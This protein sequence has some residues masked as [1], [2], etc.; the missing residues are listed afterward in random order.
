LGLTGNRTTLGARVLKILRTA[1]RTVTPA[2]VIA[3]VAVTTVA[4]PRPAAA[5][6]PAEP[7]SPTGA[8]APAFTRPVAYLRDGNIYV[9]AGATERRLT[10]GGGHARPR[11]SPD[12]RRLAFLRAG[13][14]WVM[15]ADGSGARRLD[16]RPAA[17]PAWSPDGRWIAFSSAGCT[18]VPAIYRISATQPAAAEALFPAACRDEPAPRPPAVAPAPTGP[19][20]ERLRRD[21]AVAWSPDGARIAFRGGDCESIY[22]DCLTLGNVATGGERTLVG[23]GGGGQEFSGF[24][25]VPSFRADGVKVSWTAY[26]EGSDAATTLPVHLVELDLATGATRRVGGAE[27][28]EM[29]YEGAARGVFTGRHQNASWVFVVD[30][31]TGV[32]SPFHRGSQPTI[33]S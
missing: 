12:G 4:A 5:A 2:V 30:L 19:L 21:D 28:R 27:D 18:G 33:A 16:S 26:Q 14:P 24:A 32:R 10:T 17:G 23:Y 29:A 11:W 6:A 31:R 9:S 22:D 8:A 13:Q 7:A 3:V 25:V 1:Y 15:L 20:A